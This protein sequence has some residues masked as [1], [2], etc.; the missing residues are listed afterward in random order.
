MARKLRLALVG[1]TATAVLVSLALWTA[2]WA[3]RQVRPFYQQAL[4][5]DPQTLERGKEELES[6]ATALY[7]DAHQAG[8]WR[9]LFTDEQINGW[10][11]A[12][13]SNR[14]SDLGVKESHD[15]REP[16]VAISPGQL[17]LGF[18]TTQRGVD[19]V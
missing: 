3:T 5:I 6:R 9:A 18:R 8:A 19:T 11:A 2:Y 12:E 17:T 1:L 15:F 4:A 7:T 14:S 10:L 13:L 16:R